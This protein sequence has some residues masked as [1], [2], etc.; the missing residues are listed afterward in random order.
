MCP[1]IVSHFAHRIYSVD[2]AY[3]LYAGHEPV[4]FTDPETLVYFSEKPITKQTESGRTPLR[5]PKPIAK[6]ANQK[7]AML[8]SDMQQLSELLNSLA[9]S[10]QKLHHIEFQHKICSIQYRL[11]QLHSEVDEGLE[12]CLVLAMLAFLT[13]P[14]QLP[15]NG[16]RYPY[17][18]TRFRQCFSTIDVSAPELDDLV[19]WLLTI[20]AISLYGVHDPWLQHQWRTNVPEEMKWPDAKLR[21][22][23]FIWIDTIH[24]KVG[25]LAFASLNN[26]V[27]EKDE[28][29][30][31]FW[32]SGWAM[33]P[34]RA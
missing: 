8:F 14:F 34:Y 20:A 6:L 29:S 9:G 5:I 26:G 19:L 16:I 13:T 11:L 4:F 30:R 33:C 2:F 32:A 18:S 10:K 17:L 21:L 7:V 28:P 24:G 31:G 23:K 27:V 22:R 15:Y 25:Q 3:F 12:E 1:S